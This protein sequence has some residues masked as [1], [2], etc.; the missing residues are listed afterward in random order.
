[1]GQAFAEG[2]GRVLRQARIARGLTLRQV[3]LRSGGA[4]SPSAIAGYERGERGITLERFCLL[5]ELYGIPP[6]RL[7]AEI[8]GDT[9]DVVVD[10]TPL[11]EPE[12]TPSPGR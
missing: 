2:A 7:L 1:V 11:E 9:A 8:C 10:L 6:D 3:G 4:F 12:I 5:A